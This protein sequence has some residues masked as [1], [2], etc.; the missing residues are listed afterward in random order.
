M[1]LTGEA[2][3]LRCFMDGHIRREGWTWMGYKGPEGEQRRL[4]P[5]EARLWEFGTRGP[6][7]APAGPDRKLLTA[8]EAKRFTRAKV[9]GF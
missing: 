2:V 1:A 4:T 5:P 3:F 6:G 7:T 9:I 8:A